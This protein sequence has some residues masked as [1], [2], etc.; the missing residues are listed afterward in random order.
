[1]TPR[2]EKWHKRYLEL[3]KYISS[4]SRDP[5]TKVGSVLISYKKRS[6]GTVVSLGYNGF[7]AG[8]I[9]TDDRYNDRPTKYSLVVHAEV[10]SC[11]TAGH[12]ARGCTLYIY[13][14]F[15]LPPICQD[16]CKVAITSGVSRIV[17]YVLDEEDDRARRWKDSIAVSKL[18]CDEAGIE[19]LGIPLMEN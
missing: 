18:M 2:E 6:S 8:V 12:R 7:A 4:W 11:I 15:N 14:S 17:G 1:M 13:P 5:S 9:D 16:C 19:Y 3:A 10:N